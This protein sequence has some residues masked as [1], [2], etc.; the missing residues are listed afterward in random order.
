MAN[1]NIAAF[2]YVV[3]NDNIL[4]VASD[5]AETTLSG[6]IGSGAATIP[7]TS[8]NSFNTPCLLV[9]D[10][11]IILAQGISGSDFTNCLRGFAGSTA[12][13]HTNTTD[14]FGYILSYQH[15]QV[16]AEIESV[17]SF[18]TQANFTGFATNENLLEWSED[19]TQGYWGKAS[20]VTVPS[21][22]G[23]LANGSPGT[24]MLEGN[25]NGINM[26][27]ATPDN[28][29]NGDVY[30]FSVYVK[31]NSVQYMAIGQ[32]LAG[33]EH[34]W[35]WFDVQNGLLATIGALANAC[36]V[37]VGN[38]WYRCL[39]TTACTTNSYK[40]FDIA[41]AV[42]DAS[43]TYLGTAT[44]Y[45]YIS[46]AS[47]RSGGFDGVLSYIKTSGTSFSYVGN[48]EPLLDLGDLS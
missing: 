7:V 41:L 20:G 38:G 10:S 40:N 31:Y 2:P 43:N 3:P 22:S 33:S 35:A 4:T 42:A 47:V 30:T 45:N 18:L 5:N 48:A 44:N 25:T 12:A 21:T 27:S 37:P 6:D 11:E 14:V 39:V 1:P 8:V 29:V 9:I 34:R 32:N 15:N 16:A 13:S 19:F 23:T 46:A 28:L 26:V 24:K 36:I 17:G